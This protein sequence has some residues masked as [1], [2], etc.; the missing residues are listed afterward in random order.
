MNRRHFKDHLTSKCRISSEREHQTRMAEVPGSIPTG[1][2][3]LVLIFLFFPTK[4]SDTNIAN[5]VCSSKT[6]M[7]NCRPG[8]PHFVLY[9]IHKF[10]FEH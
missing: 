3:V 4:A 2:K 1:G 9:F 6:R 7:L 5:F 10:T 8:N